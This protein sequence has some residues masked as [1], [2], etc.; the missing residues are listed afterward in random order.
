MVK[1]SIIVPVYNVQKYLRRCLDSLVGQILK[2][3]EIICINDGSTDLS[4]QILDEY[5]LTDSRVIVLKQEQ[6]G[7]SA[8][9]NRG[10]QI[11]SGEYLGF[12]DSDDWV[13]KDFFEKLYN[14]AVKNNADVAA[15]GVIRLHKYSKK[16]YLK[17]DNEIITSDT[18]K[19]FAL[20][21]I[22]EY[23]YV[24]NKIYKKE[25]FLKNNIW[26]EKGIFYEDVIITPQLMYYSKILLTVP[27]TYYYYWRHSGSTVTGKSK[28]HCKDSIYAHKKALNFI[29]SKNI[30]ISSH[31]PETYRFKVFGMTI[32]KIRKKGADIR[33][34]LFNIIEW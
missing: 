9:R 25:L 31:K 29:K 3:I 14:S 11:A 1:V 17:F 7:Q 8:A 28:K 19:K 6:S 18:D 5:F 27:E 15:A 30:D 33:R 13:D 16:F 24:W 26:F 22:P 2:D 32:F 4:E 23:S 34:I 21:D 20:C 10:I 12:V